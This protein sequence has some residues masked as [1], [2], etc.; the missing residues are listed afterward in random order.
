MSL[1]VFVALAINC[2]FGWEGKWFGAN[3]DKLAASCHMTDAYPPPSN[4]TLPTFIINLDAEAKD[5]WT[6]VT[7]TYKKEIQDVIQMTI[8]ATFMYPFRKMVN[9]AGVD[10]LLARLP[11][12]WGDEIVSIAEI[13]EMSKTD[14]FLYNLAYAL[15]GFCTSIVAQDEQGMFIIIKILHLV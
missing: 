13:L 7:T 2:V 9:D 10:S 1:L 15:M 11:N 6:E 3:D 14:V 5:R 8:A 4:R 12:D